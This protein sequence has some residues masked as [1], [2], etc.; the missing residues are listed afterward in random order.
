MMCSLELW[1]TKKF[2]VK[3]NM[4]K[5]KFQAQRTAKSV[6]C[7]DVFIAL[8]LKQVGRFCAVCQKFDHLQ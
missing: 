3:T 5:E 1:M 7:F 2:D 4:P 8:L 6:N